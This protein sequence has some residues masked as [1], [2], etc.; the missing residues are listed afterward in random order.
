VCPAL[1]H[2][3]NFASAQDF[4]PM[5][6]QVTF[7]GHPRRRA[8]PALRQRFRATELECLIDIAVQRLSLDPLLH[9]EQRERRVRRGID[10][11]SIANFDPFRGW[12]IE[13]YIASNGRCSRS[14]KTYDKRHESCGHNY[15]LKS[16][17]VD[18][19]SRVF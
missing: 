9:I 19:F 4:H 6:G 17:A 18:A 13:Y 16:E 10:L 3:D 11:C 2:V 1:E 15:P 12:T 7:V 5:H 8:C 14:K